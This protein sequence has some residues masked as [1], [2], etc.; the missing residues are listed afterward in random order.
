MTR[1]LLIIA[2]YLF[3]MLLTSL[4]YA[5][6]GLSA[7]GA[8]GGAAY[9]LIALVAARGLQRRQRA[10]AARQAITLPPISL[11]KP[12]CGAEPELEACLASFFVQDYPA[13][14][15]LFAV[16]HAGDPAVQ[17]VERLRLL[18]SH[19]PA[20]L[21]LTGEPPYANAKVYSMEL[22]AGAARYDL[23]SITD[24]D[25]AVAPDYLRALAADFASSTAGP[26]VGAVTNLYRG[27]AGADLW[28][29]LEALGMSTEFM[30]GVVV[31]E[32]LEGMKFA[33]GPAMAIRRSCLQAI[34]GFTAMKDYLADDFV[35]GNWAAAAG[36]RVVLSTHVVKHHVS[37]TG[38]LRSFKHRLRWNRSTRF[39]RPSGYLGQGF[40]YGLSWALLAF[41]LWPNWF[42]GAG[43]LAVAALR[44]ALA[45]TLG[46]GLLGDQTVFRR[47]W[48]LPLQDLPSFVSWLGGFTS[49]EILW[50]DERYRLLNDGKFELVGTRTGIAPE[51]PS[52]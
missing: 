29:K 5:L 27:V 15:I 12:L 3:F 45:F 6:F 50:R 44:V 14:E 36:W 38:F 47:L 24:S 52:A 41:L 13:Y 19:I 8:L 48:L 25:T 9:Y 21:I 17:V 7:L 51:H 49:R 16:R 32:R 28:A 37:N 4:H 30:A 42:T 22:M 31:A 20:Q 23:L 43:L 18:Y 2:N 26:E 40:T 10:A 35:L 11:L 33:L 1:R 34:G 39:S 46:A